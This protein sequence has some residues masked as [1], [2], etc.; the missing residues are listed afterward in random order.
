MILWTTIALIAVACAA[1]VLCLVL[2][3][4]G[5]RPSDLSAGAAALVFVLLLVQIVIAIVAPFTGN[6]PTGSLLEFWVYLISALLIPP[7][8]IAWALVDR[9]RWSTVV[10]GVGAF[11][12]AIMV[13]RM[14]VIWTVQLA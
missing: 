14:W 4:V 1:G 3:L 13:W 8:S 2:G 5:R 11:A 7:A 9:T 12:V 10:I 6:A